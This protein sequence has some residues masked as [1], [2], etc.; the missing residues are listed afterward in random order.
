MVHSSPLR[1]HS[2]FIVSFQDE[3]L[4]LFHNR[5]E[6]LDEARKIALYSKS[7]ER[8]L[9][10]AIVS[11][12]A[13]MSFS[14]SHSYVSAMVRA[15]EALGHG[16]LFEAVQN[17]K[18][19]VST[20]IPYDVFTD[21][22]YA[23]EDPCRPSMGFTEGLTGDEMMRRA[24]ARAMIQKSLKKLQER[25]NIRGGTPQPGP[26]VDQ[27]A[28][29]FHPPSGRSGSNTPRGSLQRRRSFSENQFQQGSGSAAA[30]TAAVYDPK[31]TCPPLQWVPN[32]LENTPYGRHNK[33][34]IPRSLSATQGAAVMRQ[35]GRGGKGSRQRRSSRESDSQVAP[36][37]SA[38]DGNESPNVSRRST[39]EI[40][41]KDVASIFQ[42][43]QL[44]GTL[45]EKKDL[46]AKKL[47]PKD[48]TI[49]A[50][51]VKNL[52]S[53]PFIGREESSDEEDISDEAVLA[54]H[55]VVLNEMKVKLTAIQESRRKSMDR[56][57]N[58]GNSQK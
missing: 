29:S 23:W 5:V 54:R 50:P 11:R 58:R 48:R 21:E 12:K 9:L 17:E 47:S 52:S 19:D 28:S 37:L 40:P 7:Q 27:S 14:F 57:K 44:P 2:G 35:S 16:S 30:T 46:E 3:Q 49:V 4:P 20:M 38:N 32:V 26:Y 45:K 36:S 31:H 39:R 33:R 53:V 10:A 22:S 8:A 42:P 56:R 43:V 41:W 1:A 24:H 34:T 51:V 6:Y 13:T 15:G 18:Y 25:H 55:Q